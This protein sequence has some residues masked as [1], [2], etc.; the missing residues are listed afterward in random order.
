MVSDFLFILTQFPL[1]C[2]VSRS[3][4]GSMYK[5]KGFLVTTLLMMQRVRQLGRAMFIGCLLVVSTR[6]AQAQVFKL[7]D[8]RAERTGGLAVP[9]SQRALLYYID[10]PH[11]D[12]TCIRQYWLDEQVRLRHTRPVRLGGKYALESLINSQHHVL[13]QF[14]KNWSDSLLSVVVDTTGRA[15]TTYRAKGR[16]FSNSLNL[17]WYDGFVTIESA[18]DRT[19]HLVSRGPT[20]QTRWQ[21]TLAP[22]EQVLGCNADSSH[23]WLTVT[24][25]AFSRTPVSHLICMNLQTGAELSR[26]R[27]GP[28]S[29][30]W[31]PGARQINAD[32]SLLVAGYTFEGAAN[33]T[34]TG[35]LFYLRLAPTGEKLAERQISLAQTAALRA[36]RGGRV[37]WSSVF[38]DQAGNVQLLGETF[39]SN[40]FGVMLLRSVLS[41][42]LVRHTALHPRD[43]L[44]LTLDTAGHTQN[45]QVVS[46]PRDRGVFK[47]RGG[48]M[49]SR[50]LAE[51]AN[52]AQTFRYRGLSAAEQQLT[53]VLRSP[54]QV[55]TLDLRTHQLSQLRQA[56]T[57]GQLDVWHV[58]AGFMLLYYQDPA[59]RTLRVERV[60]IGAP[61]P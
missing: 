19:I 42:G 24:T 27:L 25:K 9:G 33:R 38:P 13:Y 49:Q 45:A 26:T 10:K 14:K 12:S 1:L 3:L 2:R 40:S 28:V 20:M 8:V 54:Q 57:A 30:Y 44:S 5:D 52:Q 55:Q 43:I 58:G 34:G 29:G 48:Y 47:W 37:H 60:A 23:L 6:I 50:I 18:P 56:P 22:G 59:R 61:V 35:D 46:L 16:P 36:A 17:P 39:Q 51:L 21:K 31:I 15:V 11:N 41:L 7:T 32:H 4:L 53:A